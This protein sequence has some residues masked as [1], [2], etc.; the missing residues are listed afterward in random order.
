MHVPG[1]FEALVQACVNGIAVVDVGG[2]LRFANPAARDLLGEPDP[3]REPVLEL[4]HPDDRWRLRNAFRQ[5]VARPDAHP[6]M[7]LRLRGQEDD[8]RSIE[9]Q[10]V[11]LL[12]DPRVEGLFV[13]LR[14]LPERAP[15]ERALRTLGDVTLVLVSARDEPALLQRMCDAIAGTGDYLLAWVGIRQHDEA[16]TVRPV[17]SAGAVDYLDHVQVSWAEGPTGQGP[18]GRAI[19]SGEIQVVDDLRR[20]VAFRPWREQA[21]QRGLRT[22]CVL[23]LRSHGEVIGVLNIYA[24]EPGAFNP[25]AVE[26]LEKL[27]SALSYGIERLRDAR[28]LDRSLDATLEALAALTEKR[29]AYTAGHM[30]RVGTL[31]SALAA[32]LGVGPEE[33]R[34]IRIAADVHDVG[35]IVVPGEILTRPTAL[36]PEELALVRLHSRAGYD[37]LAGIDFPWPVATMVVQHHERLDGSGYPDGLEGEQIV[38]GARV[39]AVADTVEAM[40]NHRPYRPSLGLDQALDTVRSGSGTLFDPDVVD[41]CV[42]L[43]ADAEFSF[44]RNDDGPWIGPPR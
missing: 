44:A 19:R 3:D 30:F 20:D 35:K 21:L 28:R 39:I 37:V 22:S 18:S 40:T 17:A 12:D 11:N 7:D 8:W 38:L 41:A 42:H 16:R 9:V 6:Q 2:R 14:P 1:L 36:S 32:E 15:L 31:A 26:L 33:R 27:A 34:G 10:A 5:L 29:D 13:T 25:E 24:G 43:L 23:P 4:V